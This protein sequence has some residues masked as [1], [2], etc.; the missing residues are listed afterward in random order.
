MAQVQRTTQHQDNRLLAALAPDDF[1]F[2][3]P[4]LAIVDLQ[5]G[6]TLYEVGETIVH[7]YF[8]HDGMVSLVT[9]MHDGKSVEMA[10][11]GCEGLFGLVSAF[12]TRQSFGRY[13]VQL[14][15]TAS[16]TELNT[17][18]EAMAARPAIQQLVLRFTEALMAQT[19]QA[20]ACNAVHSVEARCCRW[21]LM[22]QDRAGQPDLPLTQEF[23]A[24]MLG[25]QR[26][27]VS[28]VARAIQDKGLIR[29]G[30]GIITV[31]DRPGLE[32]ASCECY[33]VIRQKFEQ[34]LPHTYQ[35]G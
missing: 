8:P 30:R 11:F 5:R 10:T 15:G 16:R 25:V 34:L 18:H 7:T 1:A 27:T 28:D 3:E 21:I 12:V 35:R 22:S 14:S 2:L 6:Q 33:E 19:L 4:H 26:S 29:L 9:I 17:M 13:I 24:E 32:A 23:L 20:V 31:T